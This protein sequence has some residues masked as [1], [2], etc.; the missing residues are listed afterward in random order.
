MDTLDFL[1]ILEAWPFSCISMVACFI[2]HS[3]ETQNVAY[4]EVSLLHPFS[5]QAAA[6]TDIA[7]PFRAG[8][9]GGKCANWEQEGGYVFKSNLTIF[10]A[11]I[12][13]EEGK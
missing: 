9:V 8:S 5:P 11:N 4:L 10:L 12:C 1:V 7:A 2:E 3:L 6:K 13:K